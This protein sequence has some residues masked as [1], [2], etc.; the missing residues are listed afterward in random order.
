M[1]ADGTLILD[2][3][4]TNTS[5]ILSSLQVIQ[6]NITN[7][8]W[9]SAPLSPLTLDLGVIQGAISWFDAVSQVYEIVE[10]LPLKASSFDMILAIEEYFLGLGQDGLAIL[11]HVIADSRSSMLGVD[12]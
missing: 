2:G 12:I 10:A 8:P 7:T 5:S 4:W 1:K 6:N 11:P 3:Q 9:A